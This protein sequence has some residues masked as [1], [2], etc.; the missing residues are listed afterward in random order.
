M[1]FLG[2]DGAWSVGAAGEI[3]CTGTAQ[4]YTTEELGS[5]INPG[6]LTAEDALQLRNLT[7]DIFVAVFV[8]L[9][10]KKVL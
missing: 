4:S 1:N 10:L 9:V 3:V 2:C 6:G 8:V 5:L 7:I